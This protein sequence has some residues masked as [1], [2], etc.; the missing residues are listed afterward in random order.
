MEEELFGKK[1]LLDEICEMGSSFAEDAE[2]EADR[3][4]LHLKTRH[5]QDHWNHT[6]EKSR[7]WGEEIEFLFDEWE[8]FAQLK[9]TIED[10]MTTAEATLADMEQDKGRTVHELEQQLEKLKVG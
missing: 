8:K 4:L 1:H 10:W 3:E 2:T 7:R 6:G 9:I 5:L